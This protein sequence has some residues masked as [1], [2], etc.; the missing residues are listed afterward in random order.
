VK[1]CWTAGADAA[2][3]MSFVLFATRQD[4]E[5]VMNMVRNSA[6][7]PGVTLNDVEVREV[8]AEA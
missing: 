4:A 5:S 7:P 1:G 6:T 3:G 8:V 2:R